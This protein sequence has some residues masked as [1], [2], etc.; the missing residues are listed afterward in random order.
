[1][2]QRSCAGK[3]VPAFGDEFAAAAQH[4]SRE[5]QWPLVGTLRLDSGRQ[6]VPTDADEGRRAV[7]PAH[8]TRQGGLWKRYEGV[9]AMPG[10]G[11]G[12]GKPPP[13]SQEGKLLV[14]PLRRE[15]GLE[16][17]RRSIEHSRSAGCAPP[18]QV[19]PAPILGG[20]AWSPSRS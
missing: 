20:R 7:L 19:P 14:G 16:T 12:W 17:L 13:F 3:E 18:S 8:R 10:G 1:K 15:V 2:A 5:G 4:R 6:V 11:G 9:Q